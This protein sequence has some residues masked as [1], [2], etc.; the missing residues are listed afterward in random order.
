MRR[1]SSRA[2]STD[3]IRTCREGS[4]NW[5]SA[6]FVIDGSPKDGHYPYHPEKGD[7]GWTEGWVQFNTP[8]AASL[9]QMAYAETSVRLTR[10]GDSLVV[11]LTAPLDFDYGKAETGT[12][13]VET[14]A[15]DRERVTVTEDSSSARSFTG[16]IPLVSRRDPVPGDGTVQA[17]PGVV[18]EAAYGFGYL[19]HRTTLAK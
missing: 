4:A 9:A 12:V 1:A 14:N 18:V 17:V 16:R 3:G 10:E 5:H 6:R 19:G 7:F 2:W 15:G 8:F 13:I 11:G